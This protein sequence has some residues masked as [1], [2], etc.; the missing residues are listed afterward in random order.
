MEELRRSGMP[1]IAPFIRRAD[2]MIGRLRRRHPH[3]LRR[4][5]T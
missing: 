4:E 3:R 1:H 5:L 2:R